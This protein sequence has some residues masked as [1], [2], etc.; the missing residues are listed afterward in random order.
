VQN[1]TLDPEFAALG[2]PAPDPTFIVHFETRVSPPDNM[3]SAAFIH[4]TG[5]TWEGMLE[6]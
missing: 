5:Q 1:K 6:V 4:K 3:H 2:Y